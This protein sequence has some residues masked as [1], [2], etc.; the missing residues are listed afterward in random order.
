[1][2]YVAVGKSGY[3]RR[4]KHRRRF[5]YLGFQK[6]IKQ[7]FS[8]L[9]LLFF[10]PPNVVKFYI[11]LCRAHTYQSTRLFPSLFCARTHTRARIFQKGT[12]APHRTARE[13]E[14]EFQ[15]ATRRKE[16]LLIIRLKSER[17]N[18]FSTLSVFCEATSSLQKKKKSCLN[19]NENTQPV[20]LRFSILT[21]VVG[22]K[23]WLQTQS[24]SAR[25]RVFT[26]SPCARLEQGKRL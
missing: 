1:M 18:F 4:E 25:V 16:S 12:T 7:R 20:R 19:L 17:R 24:E 13:R 15:R 10:P 8:P 9:S 6:K 2:M 26:A 11:L 3:T 21:T 23:T 5:L 22:E 14:R